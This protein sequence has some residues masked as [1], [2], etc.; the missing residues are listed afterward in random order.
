M[1]SPPSYQ[2][3]NPA[4]SPILYLALMSPTMPLYELDEYGQT[5]MAQRISTIS[6]VAQVNVFGSQKFA[7]RVQL[8]PRQ[9][10]TR[11]IGIDEVTTAIQGANVN[12]PSGTLTGE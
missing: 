2:K 10:A 12:L 8:D 3:V 6:G 7:V 9:L 5:M 4:D 11:G 1:P